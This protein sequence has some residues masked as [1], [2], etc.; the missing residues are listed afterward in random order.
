MSFLTRRN[1]PLTVAGWGDL[2]TVHSRPNESPIGKPWAQWNNS[3][4]ADLVS[5]VM[6][7]ADATGAIF[8]FGG[9]AYEHQPYTPN[10]GVDFELDMTVNTTQAMYFGAFIGVAWTRAISTS[11]SN[12]LILQFYKNS[13]FLTG[14]DYSRVRLVSYATSGGTETVIGEADLP[15]GINW[16]NTGGFHTIKAWFDNDK[17]FRIYIDGVLMM[18]IIVPFAQYRPGFN[19]RAFNFVNR[20]FFTASMKKFFTYDRLVSDLPSWSSFFYDDLNRPGPAVGNGWTV[21]GSAGQIVSSSIYSW[22]G[23]SDGGSAILRDTGVSTGKQRVEAVIAGSMNNTA[24]ARLFVLSNAAGTEGFCARIW[25]NKIV[26]SRY[27]TS[28]TNPSLLQLCSTVNLPSG[29]APGDIIAFSVNNDHLWVERN[30]EI[31]I[32]TAR[33]TVPN[34]NQYAGAGVSHAFFAAT[35]S[36]WTDVRILT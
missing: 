28:L 27:A 10:W 13:P 3:Q 21:L 26:I 34:T 4:T 6:V 1:R 25:G 11:D 32:G 12:L 36:A 19:K 2:D 31:I 33:V 17:T 20:C 14:G 22:T 5:D 24:D 7:F 15:G 30:G 18:W 16:F 9:W 23:G 29:N 8:N 35:S